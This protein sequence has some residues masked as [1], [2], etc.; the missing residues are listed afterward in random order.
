[1]RSCT[2]RFLRDIRSS[3]EGRLEGFTGISGFAGADGANA[4]P[5]TGGGGGGIPA[6]LCGLNDSGTPGVGCRIL[7]GAGGGGRRDWFEPGTFL[8]AGGGGGGIILA[9]DVRSLGRFPVPFVSASFLAPPLA[10][11][12]LFSGRDGGGGGGGI[13]PIM[14]R[15]DGKTKKIGSQS[16]K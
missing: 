13:F 15:R 14:K 10:G 7:E 16:S 5:P 4:T 11:G 2:Q 8:G 1:M 9:F 3:V 6:C 12:G